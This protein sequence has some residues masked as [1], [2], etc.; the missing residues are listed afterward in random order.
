[1]RKH[2]FR[3]LLL[4]GI[5]LSG[6]NSVVADTSENTHVAQQINTIRG[7][8]VDER[9]EPLIGVNVSVKNA[10][11]GAITDL[12]GKFSLN[13][14]GGSTLVIYDL[15]TGVELSL[16]AEEYNNYVKVVKPNSKNHGNLF[17][18]GTAINPMGTTLQVD[19]YGILLNGQPMTPVM[20]EFHYSRFPAT[21]WRKELLKMKAGG[22]NII[23]SY[24]FWIHHE[25]IEGKYNWEGQCNLRKFIELCRELDLLF[26]L[27]IGPWCHGEARNGGIPEWMVNSGIK[28]RGNDEAYLEKVNTW[29]TALF[30][31]VQGLMWKDGG[32]IIAVQIENEYS[33]SGEHLMSLKNMIQQIGYDA[34]FYT[35]TGWP[36]LSSPVP[37]GE[38]IPLYGDYADGF[39]DRSMKEMPGEYGKSYLFR[40]F[41]N[42]TVIATEQL[43]KQSDKDNPDDIGYPYFTCELG[44]GMMTSYHRRVSINPMDVFAMSLVRVGSGSNLPGYYMYHG[45]TNP[46]GEF[47]TMNEEQAS[48]HTNN[49]DLPVKTYD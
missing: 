20:G 7:T 9:G 1:M 6:F 19:S 25:E 18:M 32:S 42:S 14:P 33:G 30:S 35:R 27:R 10:T 43:P 22:I 11:I 48:N 37:F 40:S 36:K 26:V 24:I 17:R 2:N 44:G 15:R 38:I 8:V 3:F 5:L 39:W 47:T 4:A 12:D 13:A 16:S 28:L 23:A 21:E 34:P 29:F 46:V 49:N 31:Q 45:G 41:R